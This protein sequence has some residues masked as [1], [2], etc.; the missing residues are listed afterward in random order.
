[1]CSFNFVFLIGKI[2]APDEH[3][4][5]MLSAP[6][7]LQSTY[8]RKYSGVFLFLCGGKENNFV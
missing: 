6:S 1:M 2:P 7:N 4:E 3:K 5:S 8:N